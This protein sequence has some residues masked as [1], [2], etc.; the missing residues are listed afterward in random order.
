MRVKTGLRLLNLTD[1]LKGNFKIMDASNTKNIYIVITQTGTVLSR[2]LKRITKA[3]YNH[4][5]LGLSEDLQ[6]LYSFG[7]KFARN[8]FIGGF[9]IESPN[10]GTF[11]HFSNT[12]ALVLALPIENEKFEAISEYINDM[13][14]NRK[15]YKYNYFGLWFAA[16]NLCLKFNN[17]YYC[18]EFVR[19][20][21]KKI[22][23][24][25][26]DKMEDIVQPIHFLDIPNTTEYY[27]GKLSKFADK[28][29]VYT[30][31]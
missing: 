9:I 21:L 20:V 25:G 17:R 8:P 11:K 2:I 12:K 22:E 7:R 6:T 13:V 23:I 3:E 5:S 4:V 16:F 28:N 1:F 26:S 31:K 29:Y 27:C 30:Y 15:K 14:S 10:Y 19:D 24:E 18:S